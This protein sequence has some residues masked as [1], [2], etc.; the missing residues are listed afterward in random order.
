MLASG[1]RIVGQA[2]DGIAEDLGGDDSRVRNMLKTDADFRNVYCE[3]YDFVV[4]LVRACQEQFALL[5]TTSSTAQFY[6]FASLAHVRPQRSGTISSRRSHGKVKI[7][8]S[9][10]SNGHRSRAS[11]DR[12]ST[13]SS[14][15]SVSQDPPYPVRSSCIFCTKRP[16]SRPAMRNT[17][18]RRCGTLWARSLYVPL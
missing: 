14:A 10:F 4:T 16:R 6:L 8:R 2:L 18:R 5:A 15:R 12:S 17:S 9:T 11:T 1:W 13:R 7:S 3:V